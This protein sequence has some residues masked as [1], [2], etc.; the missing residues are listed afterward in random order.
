M[1][2]VKSGSVNCQNKE[3]ETDAIA[4]K[5]ASI[6][7]K[8]QT[9]GQQNRHRTGDQQIEQTGVGKS[10]GNLVQKKDQSQK[11]KQ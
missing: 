7:I 9:Q 8:R 2:V 10:T 4:G 3:S 1:P 5:T 11:N 6:Q